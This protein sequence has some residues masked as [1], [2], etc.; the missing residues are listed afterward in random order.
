MSGQSIQTQL[1]NSTFSWTINIICSDI[2]PDSLRR[3]TQ[4]GKK[5]N[6]WTHLLVVFELDV[7]PT[8]FDHPSVFCSWLIQCAEG[9]SKSPPKTDVEC[10][11]QWHWNVPATLSCWSLCLCFLSLSLTSSLEACYRFFHSL[12]FVVCSVCV[13]A[14]CVRGAGIGRL[15][16]EVLRWASAVFSGDGRCK[17]RIMF[18]FWVGKLSRLK[19]QP[20]FLSLSCSFLK[21]FPFS[22]PLLTQCLPQVLLIAFFYAPLSSFSLTSFNP[23]LYLF[24]S[25][26]SLPSVKQHCL[27]Y[28]FYRQQPLMLVWPL[29]RSVPTS[30]INSDGWPNVPRKYSV[31]CS[32]IEIRLNTARL[33]M[34]ASNIYKYF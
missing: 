31:K 17:Q 20:P 16:E 13:Y 6:I 5:I 25:R 18:H 3:W 26:V 34:I 14:V 11:V 9:K 12:V 27:L 19:P 28:Y 1:S 7:K 4:P 2:C 24:Q 10:A 21:K 23:L 8:G 29:W 22:S 30:Q 32:Y 33:C 15:T